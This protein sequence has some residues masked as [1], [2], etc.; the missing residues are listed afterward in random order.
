M[1]SQRGPAS[2][3]REHQGEF[4]MCEQN[5]P[6]Q[7][8]QTDPRLRGEA[9]PI[10]SVAGRRRSSSSSNL[11][12]CAESSP[13]AGGLNGL[14]LTFREREASLWAE[15]LPSRPSLATGCLSKCQST[16]II[17]FVF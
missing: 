12:E 3:A 14:G 1:A 17:Q 6:R 2:P 13:S 15:P 7:E 8:P 4:Q 9:G 5:R 11:Q 16:E 10:L